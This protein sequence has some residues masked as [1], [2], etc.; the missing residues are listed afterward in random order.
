MSTKKKK[1][2]TNTRLRQNDR[3]KTDV[4]L[5]PEL[6]D[7]LD[8]VATKLG[9][10]KNSLMVMAVARAVVDLSPVVFQK[11]S[12]R[13]KILKRM[14]SEFKSAMKGAQAA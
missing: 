12:S 7:A 2:S 5:S 8:K 3:V 14:E 4:R 6:S 1:Q 11:K 9:A 10:T 13:E